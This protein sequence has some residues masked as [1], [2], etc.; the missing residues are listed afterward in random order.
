MRTFIQKL[1]KSLMAPLSMIVAAGLMLGLAS[2]LTNQMIF[3]D[4][5][6]SVPFVDALVRCVNALAGALFS[7]LPLLFCLS[8]AIGMTREDKE[9]AAFASVI[10]F[11]LFHTTINF[12]LGLNGI[13]ADTTSIEALQAGGMGLTEATQQNAASMTPCSASSPTA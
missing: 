6:S 4:A 2:L 5:L 13:T 7:L 1:G 8:L 10:A 3:G 11:I 12:F 9:I